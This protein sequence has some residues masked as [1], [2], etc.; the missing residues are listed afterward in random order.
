MLEE[1]VAFRNDCDEVLDSRLLDDDEPDWGPVPDEEGGA[2]LNRTYRNDSKVIAPVN[3]E[4]QT[5]QSEAPASP[6]SAD[7]TDEQAN[8]EESPLFIDD[9]HQSNGSAWFFD[10]KE[11]DMDYQLG[12]FTNSGHADLSS[13]TKR[14]NDSEGQAGHGDRRQRTK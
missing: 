3:T 14:A 10:S 13:S 6:N 4:E 9:G 1:L 12:A 11:E 7:T 8:G 2:L 5:N